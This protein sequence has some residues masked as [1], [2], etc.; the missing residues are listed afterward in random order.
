MLQDANLFSFNARKQ[1][2]TFAQE[3]EGV[4]YD[5]YLL[6]DRLRIQQI[7]GN[8]LSNSIKFTDDGG[9]TLR[10]QQAED[11]SSRV[12]LNFEV[13]D[14]GCGID[15]AAL[16]RLFTPF[17]QA[18]SSTQRHYGG[19]GLGLVIAKSL[20]Q[21]MGGTVTLSSV[22]GKGTLLKI[23]IPFEKTPISDSNTD[24]SVTAAETSRRTDVLYRRREEIRILLAEDNDLVREILTRTLKRKGF[25]VVGVTDGE[26]AVVAAETSNFDCILMDG[27]MPRLDGYEATKR[28][29]NSLIPSA[30][31]VK[32]IAITASAIQDD[33]E[34]YLSVGM[35]GFL[36][37]PVR[38]IAL[39]QAIFDALGAVPE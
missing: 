16:P 34:R 10:V 32:I 17:R 31:N 36:T 18:G 13:E 8:A 4:L 25:Q 28:I 9:V 15:E 23:C 11:T 37:K 2:I 21:M 6:G 35:N 26:A 22:L 24:L 7:I 3:I 39:E 12:L 19:T 1:G 38:N 33:R 30:R 27:Q 5:G 20:A 14:T 29:R